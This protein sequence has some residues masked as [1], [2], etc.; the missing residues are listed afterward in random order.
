MLKEFF[1]TRKKP[2][3]VS[4]S[5]IPIHEEGRMPNL[6]GF[7]EMKGYAIDAYPCQQDTGVFGPG[8]FSE[9]ARELAART[10]AS[11]F[12]TSV[13]EALAQFEICI[14]PGIGFHGRIMTKRRS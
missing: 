2:E 5:H 3:L 14:V 11:H 1:G 4:A 9:D 8:D 12:G 10:V 7:E 13:Q 6:E